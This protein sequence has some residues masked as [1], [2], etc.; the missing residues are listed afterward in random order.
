MHV[1]SDY[2]EA[3]YRVVVG[4]GVAVDVDVDVG[5]LAAARQTSERLPSARSDLL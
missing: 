4:V 2:K 5:A 1:H 3:K